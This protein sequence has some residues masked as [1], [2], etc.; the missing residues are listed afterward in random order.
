MRK[1]NPARDDNAIFPETS[2]NSMIA[3]GYTDNSGSDWIG[4]VYVNTGG[5]PSI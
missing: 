4:Y 1:Y 2:L 5:V 3:D